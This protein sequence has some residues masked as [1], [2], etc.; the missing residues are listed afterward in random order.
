V[1]EL[2]LPSQSA[3]SA[4]GISGGAGVVV[5][6]ATLLDYQDAFQR[7]W[8]EL[9]YRLTDLW[10]YGLDGLACF[11][12]IFQ[13]NRGGPQQFTQHEIPFADYQALYDN[14]VAQGFRPVRVS[15]YTHHGQTMFAAIFEKDGE[16]S[17]SAD[18]NIALADLPAYL[19]QVKSSGLRVID[20]SVYMV[21]GPTWTPRVSVVCG[22]AEEREWQVVGP[23][24]FD[25]YQGTFDLN[26]PQGW[27]PA[28]VCA[29]G[30]EPYIIAR[31]EKPAPAAAPPAP[32]TAVAR[33]GLSSGAFATELA[34]QD[35]AGLRLVSL[36]AY[37][38]FTSLTTT[39]AQ[40]TDPMF[41]PLWRR[42]DAATVVPDLAIRYT[43]RYLVPGVSLAVAR[44]GRQVYAGGFGASDLAFLVAVQP[45]NQFRI[46]SVTKPITAT[47][48]FLLAARKQLSLDDLVLG[49]N[50][51]LSSLGQPVDP[52]ASQIT[53]HQLLQHAGGGWPNDANDPMFTDP[54]LTARQLITQVITTRSL[55]NP[56]GTAYAYS[57]FGYCLLGRVI[58][59]VTGQTYEDWVRANILVPCGATMMIAGDTITERQPDEVY[60]YDLLENLDPYKVPVARMDSHG[61]W[62][63]TATD[64]LRFL[65]RADG[66]PPVADLLGLADITQMTTPSNLPNSDGYACGWWTA[67]NGTWFHNGELPG[68]TSVVTRTADGFCWAALGNGS[69][70]DN[71]NTLRD[72]EAGMDNLM[73]LIRDSVDFWPLNDPL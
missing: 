53:V 38:Q 41:C 25:V 44:N 56:P 37:N 48:I 27:W 60:Y 9:G 34:T 73:W 19:D 1:V 42:Q 52:R 35:A 2:Q 24:S 71:T 5:Y 16:T 63:A 72:T 33:H 29:Y 6:N 3:I 50:G 8:A 26:T 58:E 70:I 36:G 68:T 55:D 31:W 30:D 65:V 23:M 67:P 15:G 40:Y 10:G 43:S 62:I 59:Q 39:P 51:W 54:Q 17:F 22:P 69:L 20:L 57:N 11:A 47:A 21:Y 4:Q 49:T 28:Q 64:L 13:Q 45:S 32:L 12:A 18:H 66:L 46:A 14:Q 7:Y 61:G